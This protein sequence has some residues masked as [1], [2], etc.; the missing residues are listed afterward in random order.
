MTRTLI[1]AFSTRGYTITIRDFANGLSDYG[2]QLEE[3]DVKRLFKYLD[4]TDSGKVDLADLLDV[5][6]GQE[7]SFERFDIIR[8]AY[9]KLDGA[10]TNS[11]TNCVSLDDIARAY[12]VS[13]NP[14]VTSGKLSAEQ[15]YQ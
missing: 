7:I 2:V 12:N 1:S 13:A 10:N 14:D 11:P 15:A 4:K 8:K 3:N 9:S 5:L 6:R